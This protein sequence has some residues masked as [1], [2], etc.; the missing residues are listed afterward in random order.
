MKIE[1]TLPADPRNVF[2]FLK[3]STKDGGRVS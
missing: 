1:G 3:L 2:Q